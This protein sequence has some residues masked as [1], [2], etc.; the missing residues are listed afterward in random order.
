M[1]RE[2]YTIADEVADTSHGRPHVVVLGAGAS[3][4]AFPN[5]D[6]NGRRLP[7]MADF[8][9]VVGLGP[10]LERHGIS[11]TGANFEELY[12]SLA[13]DPSA[14]DALADIEIT[15]TAYFRG[16]RMPSTATL[17]DRL[18]LSLRQ[19]DLIATFNWD[20]FLYEACYR[21]HKIAP[22]P[23]VVYLHGSVATGA[24][25][26]HRK[27]GP[28]GAPCSVCGNPF[29]PSRLLYPVTTKD[30]NTEPFIRAEWATLHSYLQDA[31]VITIFG[32]GAPQS[33]VEAVRL[34]REAW[35]NSAQRELEQTELIDIRP[36]QELTDVWDP[37]IHSHHYDVRRSL[38]DSWL[39]K[40]PRR[41][42]EAACQQFM[43][44]Q[45][46]ADHPLADTPDLVE[47]QSWLAPLIRAEAAAKPKP[48]NT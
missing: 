46:L 22:L 44:S 42:C 21:S 12:A 6:A 18:V 23:H 41:T 17:Y 7:L 36:E 32:Y 13:A 9:Q 45:F 3:L 24:C 28:P 10:T 29:A 27:K 48:N 37:F 1:T 26:E 43:G 25:L 5:G 8:V 30:Y 39:A 31:Y 19:K 2:P 38:Q 34:M 14:K 33:D 4:A 47:L 20:P 40:H 11:Y 15:V 35:G 16:M